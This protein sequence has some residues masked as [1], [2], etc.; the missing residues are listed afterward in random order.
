MMSQ[1]R[2]W[3][4]AKKI[5][6]GWLILGGLYT[7]LRMQD[8]TI[9]GVI[10]SLLGAPFVLIGWWLWRSLPPWRGL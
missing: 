8:G 4:K 9:A 3:D 1:A 6:A 10:G 2:P 5:I 7:I